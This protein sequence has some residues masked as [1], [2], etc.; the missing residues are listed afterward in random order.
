M[1]H[2]SYF[3]LVE[4]S[5][6]LHKLLL[7]WSKRASK[8]RVEDLVD[9]PKMIDQLGLMALQRRNEKKSM[10]AETLVAPQQEEVERPKKAAGR[11]D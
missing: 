5:S 9:H 11:K 7:F 2:S 10:D 1:P 4:I 3:K 8:I 6:V